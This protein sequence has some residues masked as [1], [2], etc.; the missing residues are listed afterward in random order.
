MTAWRGL[1]GV[2]VLA[3]AAL[4]LGSVNACNVPATDGRVV[5]DAPDRAT[6]A[7]VSALLEHRCGSLDCHGQS[8]RNLRLYGYEGLRLAQEGDASRP[9]SLANTTDAEVNENYLSVVGLEPE[10]MSQVVR[11]GATNPLRL[12]LLRKPL[13]TE[14]HKGGTLFQ[15]GDQQMACVTSWLAGHTDAT[16]CASATLGNP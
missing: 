14:N 15:Q 10:L 11:E 16:T 7:P 13:G 8:G 4:V 2:P 3:C 1:L 12:T 9:S 5:V 6:F